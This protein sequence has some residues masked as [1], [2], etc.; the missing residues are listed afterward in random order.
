MPNLLW[1]F[2]GEGP[3]KAELISITSCYKN[4][5]ILPL[6][7]P[8]NLNRWLNLADVHLLPQKAKAADLVLPSKLL[9]ML[10]SGRPVVASSPK[11]SELGLLAELAGI[12]VEPGDDKGFAKA[13]R[14]LASDRKLRERLGAK[15]RSA[16]ENY[17][18]RESILT[19]FESALKNLR[20]KS[21]TTRER[22]WK[23]AP[24]SSN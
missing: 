5:L 9:G 22:A 3:T 12:R 4:V 11:G 21:H 14:Q 2:A 19:Q 20:D 1:I 24:I 8:E 13:I 15:G 10:A 17:F 16:A 7:P 18:G 6:Q 23:G